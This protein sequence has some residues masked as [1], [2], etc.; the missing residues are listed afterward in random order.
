MDSQLWIT[1]TSRHICDC[2]VLQINRSN[3][4]TATAHE[5]RADEGASHAMVRQLRWA[6]RKVAHPVWLNYRIVLTAAA[7]PQAISQP[8]ENRLANHPQ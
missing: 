3:P 8:H 1:L 7:A 6:R 5:G 4:I 2:E